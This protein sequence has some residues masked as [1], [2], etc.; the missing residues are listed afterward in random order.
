MQVRQILC[1]FWPLL[2]ISV[3]LITLLRNYHRRHR[4]VEVEMKKHILSPPYSVYYKE[5]ARLP[6]HMF[7]NLRKPIPTS[8]PLQLSGRYLR[9][10]GLTSRHLLGDE[11]L[12]RHPASWGKKCNYH[13]LGQ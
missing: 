5:P 9:T 10:V 12:D 1:L 13:L 6:A 7:A 11:A 8:S 3:S 4:R 2:K